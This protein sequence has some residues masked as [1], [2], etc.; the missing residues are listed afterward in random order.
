MLDPFY[1]VVDDAGWLERLLPCGVR[2]VQL[3][4]K[5]RPEAELRR[6]V[7]R[8]PRRFAPASARS[9][10]STITGGWLSRRAAASSTWAR[11]ISTGRT[12]GAIR[13]AGLRLGVSTH[14]AAELARALAARPDYVA[15][16]PI[17][18]T[19]L[20]A[21][22]WAP[23][24]LERVAAWKARMGDLPLVAIGGLTPERAQAV[25]AAGA[26]SA[27]VVTDILRHPE[28]EARARAWLA[29]TR[30]AA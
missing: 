11:A 8:G 13:A 17:Y 1:L 9:S 4:V 16:G 21:M 20:K 24:G 28:P 18:P 30:R 6:Q 3:R 14:D 15:L 25:L 12:V 5:D 22:P 10:W 27:A 2:L 7:R 23:Q 19:V 26:D 29:A